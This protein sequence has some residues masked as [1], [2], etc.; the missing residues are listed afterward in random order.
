MQE[1]CRAAWVR[2]G[3]RIKRPGKEEFEQKTLLANRKYALEA[4]TLIAVSTTDQ[5][6]KRKLGDL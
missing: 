3:P 6:A 5:A 1:L 2:F 4:I